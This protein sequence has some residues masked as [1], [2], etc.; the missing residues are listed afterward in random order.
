MFLDIWEDISTETFLDIC[1]IPADGFLA[2][3]NGVG[4]ATLPLCHHE[5]GGADRGR[6]LQLDLGHGEGGVQLQLL[7]QDLGYGELHLGVRIY[8]HC[9][10]ILGLDAGS[11]RNWNSAGG[12]WWGKLLINSFSCRAMNLICYEIYSFCL[13]LALKYSS[14]PLIFVLDIKIKY[15]DRLI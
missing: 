14:W 7:R 1:I 10:L 2:E 4:A 11:E 3:V 8:T 15:L 12:R 5:G 9:K 6:H 13:F